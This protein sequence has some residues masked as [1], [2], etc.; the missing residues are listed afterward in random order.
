MT[1]ACMANQDQ[2]QHQDHHKLSQQLYDAQDNQEI[3]LLAM[4]KNLI[5]V[6]VMPN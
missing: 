6:L 5:S 1:R 2:E 3:Y 4:I